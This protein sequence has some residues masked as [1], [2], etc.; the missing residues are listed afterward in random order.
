[1]QVLGLDTDA[2]DAQIK[3]A[4]RKMSLKYHPDKNVDNP[5]AAAMFLAVARAHN[6]LTDPV[7]KENWAKWGN[8]DGRQSLAV[9]R[10]TPV[11]G[12]CVRAP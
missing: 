11:C 5:E 10:R 4:Y 12:T 8:P 2:T 6:T 7:A 3:S 9:R 1:V